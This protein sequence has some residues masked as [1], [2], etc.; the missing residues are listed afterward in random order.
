MGNKT[1]FS[2]IFILKENDQNRFLIWCCPLLM[3]IR[4]TSEYL[5]VSVVH[6]LLHK[7]NTAILIAY[8]TAKKVSAKQLGQFDNRTKIVRLLLLTRSLSLNELFNLGC[9]LPLFL[10]DYHWNYTRIIFIQLTLWMNIL[11]I[12]KWYDPNI[13]K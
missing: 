9:P 11:L 10:E 12:H 13:W 6:S 4:K 8:N 2:I 3:L 7:I 1:C 5:M